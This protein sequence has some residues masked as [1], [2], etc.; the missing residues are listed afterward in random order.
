MSSDLIGAMLGPYEILEFLGMYGA[1]EVFHGRAADAGGDVLIRLVG[2]GLPP[3]PVWSARFR[4]EAKAIAT[5]KHANIA[6]A[7]D[8]GEALDAHYMVTDYSSDPTLA[9]QLAEAREGRRVFSSDDIA[10][11][12]RQVAAALDHAHAHGVVHRDVSPPHISVTR[13]GQAILGDFGLAFL[14][15]R[16]ADEQSGGA[17]FAIPEYMAPEVLADFLAASPASDTYSLGVVL[18]ELLTGDLPFNVPEDVSA[19]LHAI[20]GSTPDP[21]LRNP[22]IPPSVA[23]VVITALAEAPKD[24]FKNTMQLAEALELAYRYPQ[25]VPKPKPKPKPEPALPPPPPPQPARV[26]GKRPTAERVVVRRGPSAQDERREKARLR[27]ELRAIKDQKRRKAVAQRNEVA[28]QRLSLFFKRWGSTLVALGVFV[29]IAGAIVFG[30]QAA[31]IISISV[32]RARPEQTITLPTPI[33]AAA[34]PATPTLIVLPT[35]LPT[36]TPILSP[37][38]LQPGQPTPIPA[39]E[40]TPLTV[41]TSIFRTLDGASMQFV[42]SGQFM[43]GT[44]DLTR[45]PSVRPRHPVMLSDYWIDRTEVANAQYALCVNAGVCPEPSNFRY[46]NDPGY[47]NYPVMFVNYADAAS[48]CLWL[49]KQTGQIIGLPTE[50]QWEKA[51]AW[52]PATQ[53]SRTYPWGND[54]PSPK[55]MRYQAGVD[56]KPASPVGSHPW[57]ASAYGVFDMAGNVGEWVGDWWDPNYYAR[58]GIAVDPTGPLTGTRRVTRG[59]S[60]RD[61]TVLTMSNVRNPADPSVSGDSLG[62]RCAM[63]TTRPAGGQ[64]ALT[65]LDVAQSLSDMATASAS[66]QGNDQNALSAWVNALGSLRQSLQSGDQAQ[67]QVTITA[68]QTQLGN[69]R[70]ANQI[71]ADLNWRLTGGLT[72]IA[73]QVTPLTTPVVVPTPTAGSPVPVTPT[74]PT[75]APPPAN[76]STPA[77]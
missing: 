9:D 12:V 6:P 8:F 10:F 52:D 41:G 53:T 61:D 15:T 48:Y 27:A 11:L 72:W 54:P 16:G 70:T 7:Y 62:F 14:L 2:R 22:D 36:S 33:P 77:G 20:A 68:L 44:D 13:S 49:A 39:V 23:E 66:Q 38:P 40:F 4:R 47:F 59:G 26:L 28:R 42:P 45:Q 64:F 35:A 73:N 56:D 37:T 55:L 71:T 18:Y 51:A 30:L 25:G 19:A 57:G 43:M 1:A 74:T 17:S 29:V 34:I 46:F 3:D 60:W 32:A 31:G 75:L 24:R 76:T 63:T 67:V 58:T 65:A 21:R 69:M 5:L 50:A